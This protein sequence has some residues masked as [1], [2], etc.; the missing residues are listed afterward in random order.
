MSDCEGKSIVSMFS[1]VVLLTAGLCLPSPAA[2]GSGPM[3]TILLKDY[4]PDSSLVVPVTKV[5]RARFKVID[6]HSHVYVEKPEQIAEW[7]HIMDEVGI[8]TTIVLTG[9]TG[10]QFDNLVDKF[11]KPYSGRFQLYCGLDTRN[12]E[13]SDY[14]ERAATEL[15]RCYRK[16]ARGVGEIIDKGSG[17]TPGALRPRNKRLHPDDPRLDL[18]WEKCA[19]LK[20]PVSLHMADHP[21]AWRPPDLHQERSPSYQEYNQYGKDVPSYQE[22]LAIRNRTLAR[23]PKTL[24]VLCHLA[25]QG[26]DLASL[27]KLLD[28]FPHVYVDIS[29]RAYEVGRQPHFASQFLARYKD[30]VLFGTDQDFDL[31]KGMYLAWWRILET[32]DEYLPSDAGWR[33]YGLDLPPPVLEPIYRGNAKKILNWE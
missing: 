26:N 23:H 6:A 33:L 9:A 31:Q 17:L 8:E 12:I 21:S 4:R 22:V 11:L 32:P 20:M 14:P 7:V 18:F 13:A 30:R 2:H 28:Q 19:Q 15:E 16:G 24:F 1:A 3:D 5:E 29:A 25:N 10:R 27:A